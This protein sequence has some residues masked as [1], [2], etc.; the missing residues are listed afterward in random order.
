MQARIRL[1]VQRGFTLLEL[2]I[3]L[4]IF[5]I[6]LVI[7]T[8]VLSGHLRLFRDSNEERRNLHEARLAMEAVVDV[9]D[10][11]RRDDG[12]K[13]E[14]DASRNTIWGV[15]DDP[16]PESQPLVSKVDDSARICL[17]NGELKNASGQL[18]ARGVVLDLSALTHDDVEIIVHGSPVVF[19]DQDEFKF[20]RIEIE[21]G[22]PAEGGYGLTT[23]VGT[24]P[25]S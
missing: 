22:D 20:I 16:V 5:A 2:M 12:Y 21:A 3:A 18:I 14:L 19:E 15:R 17:D 7:I 8:S 4:G 23:I 24:K 9:L 1:R 10:K 6:V 25:R 13:L 11:A